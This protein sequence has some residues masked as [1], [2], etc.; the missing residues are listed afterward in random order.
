MESTMEM[1]W[2]IKREVSEEYLSMSC[3][4]RDKRSKE[5]LDWFNSEMSKY[6]KAGSGGV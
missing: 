1:I 4:E 2:R 6:R 5:T 3:E